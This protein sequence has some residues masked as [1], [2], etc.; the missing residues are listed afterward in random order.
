MIYKF[1]ISIILVLV[2]QNTRTMMQPR[3]YMQKQ[4]NT[5]NNVR[6][7]SLLNKSTGILVT[8]YAKNN[9][10]V[11]KRDNPA[12]D[13]IIY[14]ATINKG[15]ATEQLS[16]ESARILFNQLEYEYEK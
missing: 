12:T 2:I 6:L 16:G 4:T 10:H 7:D 13:T 1:I 3:P 8:M 5:K 15:N 9:I 11:I 14:L